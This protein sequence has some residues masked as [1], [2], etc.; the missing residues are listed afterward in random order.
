MRGPSDSAAV[1]ACAA[2][3]AKRHTASPLGAGAASKPAPLADWL[4]P[5][6]GS[7]SGVAPC[8]PSARAP[9]A[10]VAQTTARG[11]SSAL[12]RAGAAED[13]SGVAA[14]MAGAV[15]RPPTSGRAA[16]CRAAPLAAIA[17]RRA[18]SGN[19]VPLCS[20]S[21]PSAPLVDETAPSTSAALAPS[22]IT[23]TT[24]RP[25]TRAPAACAGRDRLAVHARAPET[26][27]AASA[28]ATSTSASLRADA[29]STR[30]S[31]SS[32]LPTTL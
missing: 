29:F 30:R 17:A 1:A 24:R 23:A 27:H 3:I 4:A 26:L 20:P 15:P 32:M 21:A 6:D 25:S 16:T 28:Q 5:P 14:A 13:G 2:P 10:G 9:L 7:G 12:S 19:G 22:S 8:T 18:Y 11:P 31:R